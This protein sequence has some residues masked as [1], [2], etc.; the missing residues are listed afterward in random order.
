MEIVLCKKCKST[1][2]KFAKQNHTILCRK[3]AN[4]GKNNPNY[5]NG[6]HL[7]TPKICPDCGNKMDSRSKICFNCFIQQRLN[8]KPDNYIDGRTNKK[9]YCRDCKKEI[10]QYSGIYGNGK[11]RSCAAR[12]NGLPKCIDCKKELKRYNN[13]RCKK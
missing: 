8:H 1:L 3:C 7:R 4:A 2:G 12:K 10:S 11:C 9:Y 6:S 5:K 13:L